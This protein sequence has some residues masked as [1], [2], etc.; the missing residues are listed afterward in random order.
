[1]NIVMS[2]LVGGILGWASYSVLGFNEA[3]GKIASI[4]IGALGGLVGGQML[5][6][7]FTAA[8]TSA[9]AS[10]DLSV[11]VLA[12]AAAVAAAF[13]AVGNM[14]YNRWGV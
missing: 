1:M 5:A 10:G 4:S 8:A 7:M 11:S 3:R 6:P 13:L 14:V 9:A 12:F 2:M